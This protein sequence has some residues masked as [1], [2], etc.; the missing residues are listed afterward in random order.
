MLLPPINYCQQLKIS[1]AFKYFIQRILVEEFIVVYDLILFTD[2]TIDLQSV[3]VDVTILVTLLN[4]LQLGEMDDL[5]FSG[6]RN[7]VSVYNGGI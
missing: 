4:S 7:F 3:N 6:S 5:S 1:V 2:T